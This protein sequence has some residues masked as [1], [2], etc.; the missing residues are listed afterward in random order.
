MEDIIKTIGS[1]IAALCVAA[2]ILGICHVCRVLGLE[3]DAAKGHIECNSKM[4]Y[5]PNIGVQL[6]TNPI[7]KW[8]PSNVY[9]H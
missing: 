9:H 3:K 7:Y 8:H 4:H 1:W 2:I 5:G 6:S